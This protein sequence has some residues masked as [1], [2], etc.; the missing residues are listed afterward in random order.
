MND[1]TDGTRP[2][3]ISANAASNRYWDNPALYNR[4]RPLFLRYLPVIKHI[5]A[6]GWQPVTRAEVSAPGV[7]IER[8]GSWPDLHFTLR[9]MDT[10]T[11]T[12]TVTVEAG[13]LGLPSGQLAAEGLLSSQVALLEGSGATRSFGMTLG[14]L[15]TEVMELRMPAAV[16][17][18]WMYNGVAPDGETRV[19]ALPR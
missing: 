15:A 1:T 10:T 11:V 8:F 13:G 17:D 18:W 12:V 19:R 2:S 7:Y 6:A 5:N 4:D 3:G 9:N 14:S 16:D